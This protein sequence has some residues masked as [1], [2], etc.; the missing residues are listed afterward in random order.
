MAKPARRQNAVQEAVHALVGIN[1][2]NS[3]HPDDSIIHAFSYLWLRGC[4]PEI[5]YRT[6][7]WHSVKTVE[8]AADW[9]INRSKL[10]KDLTSGEEQAVRAYLHS[11]SEN[12]MV[13]ET[14]S[15]TII[16]MLWHI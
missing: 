12:G 5:T 3:G 2:N 11:I 13:T 6:E 10:Q 7:H 8:D 1:E 16:T 4:S 14:T 15:T 9:Y